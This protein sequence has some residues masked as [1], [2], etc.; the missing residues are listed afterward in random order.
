M[1]VN[2]YVC[3]QC[4]DIYDDLEGHWQCGCEAWYCEGCVERA[5]ERGSPVA[6]DDNNACIACTSDL[7]RR[8]IVTDRDLLRWFIA[9]HYTSRS[10]AETAFLVSDLTF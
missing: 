4:T 6:L 9:K 10:A 1:G 7:N 5:V 8:T 2:Y 3:A